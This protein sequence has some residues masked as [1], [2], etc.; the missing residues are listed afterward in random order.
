M[1]YHLGNTWHIWCTIFPTTLDYTVRHI[2]VYS[3]HI[4]IMN[5]MTT[6][7]VVGNISRIQY[8]RNV[9]WAQSPY[10][11]CHTQSIDYLVCKEIKLNARS[12]ISCFTFINHIESHNLS[13]KN[14][15]NPL[16]NINCFNLYYS[17]FLYILTTYN[18]PY[19]HTYILVHI[20]N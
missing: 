1:L 20:C 5:F 17:F 14:R 6:R 18:I 19:L 16:H 9:R 15:Y 8:T 11:P 2:S 3:Y 4:V 10:S 7:R 12:K 13:V